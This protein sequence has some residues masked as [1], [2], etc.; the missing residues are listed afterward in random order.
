MQ[1]TKI[2]SQTC[3]GEINPTND[4]YY[5]CEYCGMVYEVKERKVVIRDCQT[6]KVYKEG[7]KE[8]QQLLGSCCRST[9]AR[10]DNVAVDK[11][12]ISEVVKG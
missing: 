2:Q 11:Q 5:K 6:N 9:Y 12:A 1:L 7:S 10:L 4:K 8:M 3:G